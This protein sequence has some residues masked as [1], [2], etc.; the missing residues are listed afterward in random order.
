MASHRDDFQAFHDLLD[1]DQFPLAAAG[2]YAIGAIPIFTRFQVA[3][4]EPAGTALP[5]PHRVDRA[6][7]AFVVQ[8]AVAVGLF[9]Q[10][11]PA[12]R[13]PSTTRFEFPPR[14][15]EMRCDGGD[16]PGVHPDEP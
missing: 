6:A 11:D 3:V 15:A 10:G 2:A 8:H 4:P 9:A 16:I 1:R 13:R 7:P 14:L 5:R 12:P